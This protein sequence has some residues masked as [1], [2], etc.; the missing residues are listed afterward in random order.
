MEI[1][2][3]IANKII[4]K[5]KVTLDCSFGRG[6]LGMA[7]YLFRYARLTSDEYYYNQ[8]FEM[9]DK[10]HEYIFDLSKP[11][12]DCLVLE[13][14][15]VFSY[16]HA[17]DLVDIDLDE[18][19]S[20][21]DDDLH[22]KCL[23][24]ESNGLDRYLIPAGFYFLRRY[25]D[26]RRE[27][28]RMMIAEALLGIVDE[29]KKLYPKWR[30]EFEF[31]GILDQ[32]RILDHR[33]TTAILTLLLT[34]IYE[35]GIGQALLLPSL[36]QLREDLENFT[37]I[38]AIPAT[39]G[40]AANLF[41][42]YALQN[43]AKSS[44]PI[45]PTGSLLS[46]AGISSTAFFE[47]KYSPYSSEIVQAAWLLKLISPETEYRITEKVTLN[48]LSQKT[49]ALNCSRGIADLGV[50]GGIAGA[51]LALM[52]TLPGE[53]ALPIELLAMIGKY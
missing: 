37:G 6:S 38:S 3:N 33:K 4:Q 5:E 46:S 22:G 1:L 9:L 34:N 2:A 36:L 18:L 21:N 8:A 49:G 11:K 47:E 42:Q 17:E 23:Y 29:L 44:A 14:G 24:T 35:A 16:L 40:F 53:K 39:P 12:L 13:L 45:V 31:S 25:H 15:M 43:L 51:G 7:I 26:T 20:K 19:L 27:D 30:S 32:H 50:N 41:I 52:A 10:V 48:L 28:R